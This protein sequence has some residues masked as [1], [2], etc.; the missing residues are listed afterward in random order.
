VFVEQDGQDYEDGTPLV[1]IT[2]GTPEYLESAVRND[3]GSV[4]LRARAMWKP[5]WQA[6]LRVRYDAEQFTAE[7]VSNLLERAGQQVGVGEGRAFSRDSHGMGWGFF[8][9]AKK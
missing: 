7:D 4:D 2:K 9:I 8:T 3:N 6:K 1:K 5:G